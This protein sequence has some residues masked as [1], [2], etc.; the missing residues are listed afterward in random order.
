MQIWIQKNRVSINWIDSFLKEAKI[1]MFRTFLMKLVDLHS[2]IREIIWELIIT[3]SI[4]NIASN[5]KLV[6]NFC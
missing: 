6:I 4:H 3:H 1:L 5:V 2:Q